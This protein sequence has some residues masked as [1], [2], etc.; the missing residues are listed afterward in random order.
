MGLQDNKRV[1]RRFYEEA[2]GGNLDIVE[3]LVGP[4]FLLH[5]RG[6]D[7]HCKLDDARQIMKG[8]RSAFPDWKVTIHELI[9]ENDLV[10]SNLTITGTHRGRFR[11]VEHT[12]RS[13]EFNGVFIDRV[14]DGKIV[15][16]WHS[17][18]YLTLL[19]QIGAV[20]EDIMVG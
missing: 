9:A 15:E 3:E 20:P 12:G 18:D 17:P 19:I 8:Q 2:H 1:V 6:P 4:E 14:R 13:V 5:G 10:V 11:K 16:M 7:R